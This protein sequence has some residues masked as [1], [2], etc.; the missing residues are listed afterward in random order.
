M[1]MHLV[2]QTNQDYFFGPLHL[3]AGVGTGTLDVDDVSATSLYLTDDT[4]AD[5]INTLYGSPEGLV[6]AGQ[7]SIYLRR[8]TSGGTQLY[9]KSTGI[10]VNTGWFALAGTDATGWVAVAGVL[11]YSSADGHT[12]VVTTGGADFTG[13]VPVGARVRLTHTAT[14]KYFIVTAIDATTIT[15]YGG[16]NFALDNNPITLPQFATAKCPIGFPLDPTGWTEQLKD[17]AA[18]S[19]ASPTTSTWYNLGSLSLA[20]PVGAWLLEYECIAASSHNNSVTSQKV[21]L[22]TGNSTESDTD[23]TC[24]GSIQQT[25]S[26]T[27]AATNMEIP[28][29]RRKSVVLGAKTTY[30]LNAMTQNASP[31]QIQFAGNDSATIIRAV[32]AYL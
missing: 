12:F 23:L 6:Y 28:V 2:N 21:T 29:W 25:S 32:C 17:T 18:R 31:T 22:S 15:L 26:A 10:H 1:T 8:D 13:T 14:T 3:P 4:V 20:I 7:G 11:T 24:M 16:T 30:F 5:A 27:G 19:Q 9:Q